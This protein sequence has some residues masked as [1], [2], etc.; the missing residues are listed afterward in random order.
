MKD[1][2]REKE[3]SQQVYDR[4]W[5]HLVEVNG[6]VDMELVKNELA[7]Y[8]FVLDQVPLVY[9]ELTGSRVSKPNTYAFEVIREAQ[10]YIEDSRNSTALDDIEMFAEECETKEEL[11]EQIRD[12]LAEKD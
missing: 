2:L 5:K 12:Y 6:V 1:E 10:N 8:E 11:M 9:C 7:D 3:T 4:Y